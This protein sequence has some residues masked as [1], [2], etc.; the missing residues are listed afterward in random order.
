MKLKI[1]TLEDNKMLFFPTILIFTHNDNV[2][3]IDY[4]FH[5]ILIVL[6]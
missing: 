6:F 2:F 1:R 5:F 3:I 4:S